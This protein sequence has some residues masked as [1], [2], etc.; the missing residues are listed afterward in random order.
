MKRLIITS[1]T[2]LLAFAGCRSSRPVTMIDGFAQGTT[3]H[4]VLITSDTVGLMDQVDSVFA[5]ADNSMSIYNDSSLLSRLNRNETDSV[6]AMIGRCI[7]VAQLTP[8]ASDGM[9]DITVMPL[10]RAW[11]FAARGQSGEPDL[12]SLLQFVG[13]DKISVRRGRLVK[14]D[15]RVMIDL[16]SIAKGYTCD[17]MGDL[18]EQRGVDDYMIEIGGEIVARGRNQ[19]GKPWRIGIDKPYDGN[20]TPGA[21]LQVVLGITDKALATSGNYRKFHTDTKGNKVVHTIDPKTGRATAGNMLS[22]TVIAPTCILADAYGTMLMVL[23]MEKSIEFLEQNP[24]VLGYLIY[25]DPSGMM[26]TWM[27]PGLEKMVQ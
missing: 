22:A 1:V 5:A 24:D 14:A 6:D 10:T 21:E 13:I 12:D 3:Y 2:F 25:S 4:F 7:D 11:G 17:L 19:Q 8:R 18:M 26:H 16:N 9:Y 27:S 23:G 20:F 15:P